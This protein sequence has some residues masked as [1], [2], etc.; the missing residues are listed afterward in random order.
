MM[1]TSQVGWQNEELK[2]GGSDYNTFW[3]PDQPQST[4][5]AAPIFPGNVAFSVWQ[6][7]GV[8][9]DP[10]PV[11]CG[12]TQSSLLVSAACGSAWDINTTTKKFRL[13]PHRADY[14]TPGERS[15]HHTH[16]NGVNSLRSRSQFCSSV[17]FPFFANLP[18]CDA[19]TLGQSAA[20]KLTKLTKLAQGAPGTGTACQGGTHCVFDSKYCIDL[21]GPL[22]GQCSIKEDEVEAKCGVWDA[23]DGVVCDKS[24]TDAH[25]VLYCLARRTMSSDTDTTHWGYTKSSPGAL[26]INI[27]CHGER[28]R[29]EK[30]V[31]IWTKPRFT[32]IRFWC[33]FIVYGRIK[34]HKGRGETV[35]KEQPTPVSGFSG[36]TF[37]MTPRYHC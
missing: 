31:D 13:L 27:D 19:T 4:T 33:V 8:P 30:T 5:A 11:K 12:A 29:S 24:Y 37:A 6:G 15:Q 7:K 23:C 18:R 14:A 25:G 10:T 35:R 21:G 3:N 1:M 26:V 20:H 9:V 28:S 32:Q 16:H 17:F 34:T 2:H 22:S 36:V